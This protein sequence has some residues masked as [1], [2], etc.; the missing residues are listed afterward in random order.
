MLDTEGGC[1]AL[2][3]W[4]TLHIQEPER[5]IAGSK[6]RSELEEVQ[7][8]TERSC[9][10]GNSHQILRNSRNKTGLLG[11]VNRSQKYYAFAR[12]KVMMRSDA[13]RIVVEATVKQPLLWSDHGT[14]ALVSLTEELTEQTEPEMCIFLQSLEMLENSQ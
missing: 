3:I 1:T 2:A 8:E 10:D 14:S 4:S 9:S 12:G 7:R 11:K 6:Y 13:V 5:G